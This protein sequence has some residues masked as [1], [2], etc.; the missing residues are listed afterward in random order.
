[1]K[2]ISRNNGKSSTIKVQIEN[3]SGNKIECI[4]ISSGLKVKAIK[5]EEMNLNVGQVVILEFRG[6]TKNSGY[7]VVDDLIEEMDAIVLEAQHI[8]S[9][10]ILYT[11]TILENTITKRRMYSLIPSYE[12]LFNITNVIIKG[13]KVKIRVNNGQIFDIINCQGG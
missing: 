4:H 10:G 12:K 5:R 3:I 8:I 6:N 13:D 7:I 2:L 11:S 9:D 1:M